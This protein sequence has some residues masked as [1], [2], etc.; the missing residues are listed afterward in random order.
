VN[1]D[2]NRRL[3]ISLKWKFCYGLDFAPDA[4]KA[5]SSPNPQVTFSSWTPS[6]TD[7]QRWPRLGILHLIFEGVGYFTSSACRSIGIHRIMSWFGFDDQTATIHK[8]LTGGS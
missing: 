7:P 5:K 1:Y 3:R 4:G 6:P 8:F 2:R